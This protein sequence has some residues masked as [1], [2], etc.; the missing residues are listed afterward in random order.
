MN[1]SKA[2]S[3]A[4]KILARIQKRG[5]DN[6]W[7]FKD[8]SDLP[9]MPVA[10]ALSRLSKAGVLERLHKGVYYFPMTTTFGKSR[11]DPERVAEATLSINGTRSV[12]SGFSQFNRLGLTTQVSGAMTLAT[13]R[14]VRKKK[15][16]GVPIRSSTRR[17]E[18]Q[19]HITT[20][21]R[22]I[23][24]ALR[25]IHGIP[26]TKPADVLKRIGSMI[27][28]NKFNL[29]H[30]TQFALSEPPRVRGLLGALIE[31]HRPSSPSKARLLSLL[32]KNI[33]GLSTFRIPGVAETLPTAADW[34]IE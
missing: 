4:S 5:G 19:K 12:K 29:N 11:P 6:L 24:E 14:R 13:D 34:R 23:L 18:E 17:L 21:E 31:F 2:E 22:A 9:S 28:A 25:N 10:A 20:E 33:N 15:I 7:T 27:K 3:I 1:K 30:L 26:D 32:R 16:L 8:F